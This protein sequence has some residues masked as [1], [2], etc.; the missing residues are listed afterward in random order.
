MEKDDMGGSYS[1]HGIVEKY[2]HFGRKTWRE[3]TT[4]KTKV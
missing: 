3:E 1:T 4:R 2:M